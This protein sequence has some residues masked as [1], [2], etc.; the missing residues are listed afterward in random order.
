ME[1]GYAVEILEPD[2]PWRFKTAELARYIFHTY[3]YMY[4]YMY[5]YQSK[6]KGNY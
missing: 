6:L 4:M 3:M 2:T 1:H 5:H